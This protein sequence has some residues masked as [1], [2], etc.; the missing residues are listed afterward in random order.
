ME[1]VAGH[2]DVRFVVHSTWRESHT[3]EALLAYFGDHRHRVVGVTDPKE[4]KH[5]SILA[6]LQT[7]PEVRDWRILDD[8]H[9]EFQVKPADIEMDEPAILA[10]ELI[11]CHDQL[12]LTE[13]AVQQALTQWLQTTAPV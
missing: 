6:W 9:A 5:A 7:H 10:D 13:P 8:A 11:P 1:L 2:P 3:E 4:A 12:G